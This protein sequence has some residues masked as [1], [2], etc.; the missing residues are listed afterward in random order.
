MKLIERKMYDIP[1]RCRHYKKTKLYLFLESFMNSDMA[2][3]EVTHQEYKDAN[4]CSSSIAGSI[5]RYRFPVD[6]MTRKGHV[7]L[8]KKEQ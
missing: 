7:Y 1:N 2:V 6:V 4:S 3:A 8:I 5:K